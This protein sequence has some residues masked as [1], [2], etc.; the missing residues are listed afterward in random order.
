V[1]ENGDGACARPYSV[2]RLRLEH[3]P[4]VCAL[5]QR[6]FP[7]NL[8]VRLGAGLLREFVRAY[9]L[10]EGGV[11]F[12]CTR[13]REVIGFVL[14]AENACRFR[15][16]WIRQR[17]APLLWHVSKGLLAHP[18]L[19]ART[20]RN[21]HPYLL[22]PRLLGRRMTAVPK[23]PRSP[24]TLILLAVDQAHRR[25][26]LADRLA[27]TFLGELARRS[28]SSVKLSVNA[29]NEPALRFY[30]S[31]GWRFRESYHTPDN[32]LVYLLT[33]DLDPA[34][35]ATTRWNAA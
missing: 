33:Y 11:G 13:E 15:S 2:E 26:G 7:D 18:R 10:V 5:L 30:R 22:P 19:L 31:R 35:V 24:G 6:V 9:A 8:M 32:D 34:A 16:G 3:V 4:G 25:R 14:G 21:L 17:W 27:D 1:A 12:V 28:V 29:R 23:E 20:V